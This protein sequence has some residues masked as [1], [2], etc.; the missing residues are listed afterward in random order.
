METVDGEVVDFKKLA[1]SVVGDAVSYP[2][3]VIADGDGHHA[4]RTQE[5]SATR[6]SH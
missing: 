6:P 1:D 5:I 3:L 4:G 2:E